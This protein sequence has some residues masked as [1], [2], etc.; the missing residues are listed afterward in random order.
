MAERAPFVLEARDLSVVL[1]GVRALD[2][3]SLTLEPGVRT[4]VLGPNGAGKSR[5]TRLKRSEVKGT[6]SM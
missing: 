6:S 1:G 2:G 5:R 4:V 3:L